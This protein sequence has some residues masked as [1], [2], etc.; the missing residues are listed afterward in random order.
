MAKD[1]V[2]KSLLIPTCHDEGELIPD[3]CSSRLEAV[4]IGAQLNLMVGILILVSDAALRHAIPSSVPSGPP[5]SQAASG[6]GTTPSN[7]PVSIR[8]ST[9]EIVPVVMTAFHP[10]LKP[11]TTDGA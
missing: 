5:S 9:C 1:D 8:I 10:I 7:P 3:S 11:P 4:S 2:R 6:R